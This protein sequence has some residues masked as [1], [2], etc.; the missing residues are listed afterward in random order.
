MRIW[1]SQSTVMKRNVGSIGVIHDFEIE[2]VALGDG[3]PVRDAR[4]A[5]RID[6]DA[7]L[8]V[9][10]RFQ[11]HH[12][13]EIADVGVEVGVPVRRRRSASAL[14]RHSRRRRAARRR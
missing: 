7:D 5:Q 11:V 12:R 9:A 6:A 10:D 4:A 1:P 2:T 8:A 14:E 13:G 3:V